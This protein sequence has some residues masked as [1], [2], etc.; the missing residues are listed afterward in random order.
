MVLGVL[1]GTVITTRILEDALEGYKKQTYMLIVGFVFG[2][3]F[4][5]IPGLPM[6]YDVIV[7]AR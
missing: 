3:V 5:I 1:V 6:G 2:S 7:C 4:E